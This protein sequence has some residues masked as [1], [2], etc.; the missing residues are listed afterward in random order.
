MENIT[1]EGK[2][3]QW[4]VIRNNSDGTF[5]CECICGIRKNV[6]ETWILSGFFKNCGCRKAKAKD[7]R[8]IRFGNL[9]AIEPT[10]VQSCD[11]SIK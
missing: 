10:A 2:Y 7:L 1:K 9:I 6:L 8:N 11:K 5:L 3:G 4:T